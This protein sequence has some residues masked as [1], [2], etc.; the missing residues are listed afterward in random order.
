MLAM[1]P[2]DT[3]PWSLEAPIQVHGSWTLPRLG[4]QDLQRTQ[5]SPSYLPWALSTCIRSLAGQSVHELLACSLLHCILTATLY[6]T[7]AMPPTV[8][9]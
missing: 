4:Q 5:T 7:E 2:A 6:L 8:M 3:T 1:A 9:L